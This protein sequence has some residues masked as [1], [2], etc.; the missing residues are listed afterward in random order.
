M[1]VGFIGLGHMGSGMAANLVKAGH[2]VTVYNRTEGRTEPLVALGAKA[3][4]NLAE[5]C[6]GDAVFTML[7][8]DDA[9][10]SVVYGDKGVLAHLPRGQSISRQARSALA[11]RSDLRLI[12]PVPASASSPR[13]SS[14]VQMWL[15]QANSM[16]SPPASPMLSLLREI[17]S[18]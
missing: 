7:A 16:S 4:K 6:K 8:N 15:L 10:K 17:S 3:A 1:N 18:T 12:M 11:Y 2:T 14:D 13:Q 9:V 5:A